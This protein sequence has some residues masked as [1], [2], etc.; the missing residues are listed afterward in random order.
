[1][2]SGCGG[3]LH[4]WSAR[5]NSNHTRQPSVRHTRAHPVLPHRSSLIDN[6]I[7]DILHTGAHLSRCK[8][9]TS[10]QGGVPGLCIWSFSLRRSPKRSLIREIKM[11]ENLALL[12]RAQELGGSLPHS[13]R[14][15]DVRGRG[16]L[17]CGSHQRR[18]SGT[19]T[20]LTPISDG[21]NEHASQSHSPWGTTM[22]KAGLRYATLSSNKEDTPC[23][24]SASFVLLIGDSENK[25]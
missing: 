1:M 18:C 16:D 15:R 8:C 7:Q 13:T 17:R 21:S 12:E 11:G 5:G 9:V 4:A 3:R 22:G 14:L 24:P 2:E 20:R 23:N 10:L 19:H 6:Q 25:E